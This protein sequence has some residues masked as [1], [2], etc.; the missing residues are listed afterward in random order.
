MDLIGLVGMG[1]RSYVTAMRKNDPLGPNPYK[2]V[3]PRH[4]SEGAKPFVTKQEV[5]FS[6]AGVMAWILAATVATV[7][8]HAIKDASRPIASLPTAQQGAS[9]NIHR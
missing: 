7:V 5:A 4:L 9:D 3:D 6:Y 2:Q 1:A 8:G